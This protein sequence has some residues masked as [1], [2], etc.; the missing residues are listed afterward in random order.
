MQLSTVWPWALAAVLLVATLIVVLLVFL[1][2]KAAKA[3]K[4]PMPGEQPEMDEPLETPA[5]TAE[6]GLVVGLSEAFRKAGHLLDRV[7][8]GDRHDVPLLLLLGGAR[9]RDSDM[10]ARCGLDMPWGPPSEGGMSLGAGRGFWFYDRGAIV[11]LAGDAVLREDGKTADDKTWNDG[12]RHLVEL[13]PKRPVDGLIL[14]LSA[15]ELL[16]AASSEGRRADLASRAGRLFRRL[17]DAQQRLGFRLPTYVVVTGCERLTGFRSLCSG[18]PE[19]SRKQMLGWSSPYSIESVYRTAWIDEAFD[20]VIKRLEDVQMEIF[21]DGTAEAEWLLGLPK[22]VAALAGPVRTCLDNVFRPT[23]YHGALILRGVYFCGREELGPAEEAQPIG[24]V[25]FLHDLLDKKAFSEA[26]LAQPTARTAV[27]RSRNVRIAQWSTV[28]T[29]AFVTAALLWS[30]FL[31]DHQNKHVKPF[32][33]TAVDYSRLERQR[34]ADGEPLNRAELHAG[35]LELLTR[36]SEIDFSHYGPLTLPASWFSKFDSRLEQSVSVAFDDVILDALRF[37]LETRARNTITNA[38]AQLI[39]AE[40]ATGASPLVTLQNMPAQGLLTGIVPASLT[41]TMPGAL[42]AT[43]SMPA[44]TLPAQASTPLL[45]IDDMPELASLRTYVTEMRQLEATARSFNALADTGDINDLA[46]VIRYALHRNMPKKFFTNST[47]YQA[48]L[49][50]SNYERFRPQRYHDDASRALDQ[51]AGNFYAGLYRR[52]PFAL[53][54]QQLAPQLQRASWYGSADANETATFQ[55]LSRQLREVETALAGPE[56]EWA[57]RTTFDLGPAYD[58]IVPEIGQSAFFG[59]DVARDFRDDGMN[60]WSEFRTNIANASSLLTGPILAVENGN[61]QMR[62]SSDTLLLKYALDTFLGQAFVSTVPRGRQM[63]VDLPNGVRLEWVPALLDQANAVS[64]AYDRFREKSLPMFP[65]DMR[66][67]IDQVARDRARNEMFDLVADAQ[68]FEPVPPPVS[69]TQLE[70]EVAGGVATFNN[71]VASLGSISESFSRIGAT[72]SQRDLANA[73][74]SEAFRLLQDL[75]QLLDSEQPYVPRQGNFD[76]WDGTVPPSPAAWGAHD[77]AELATYLDAVRGRVAFLSSNYAKPLLAWFQRA[78]TA[79][80]PEIRLTAAKWQTIVDALAAYDA[81]KPGNA[82]AQ[83]EDYISTRAAKVTPGDCAS[84]AMPA[85]IRAS[86]GYYP[87]TL[88]NISRLLTDR[89]NAIAG[90]DAMQRYAEVARY[91]N[92]RLSGRYPFA[93]Q[94][95]IGNQPEADPA[96]IRAFFRIFDANKSVIS[97]APGSGGLDAAAAQARSFMDDMAHVRAFFAPYLDAPKADAAPAVDVEPTFRVMRKREIDGDQIIVWDLSIG[98]D[99]ITNRDKAAKLRWTA[100]DPVRVS[101]RWAIDAPRVPVLTSP[102]RWATVRDRT[103]TYEYT[104]RWA[105]ITALNAHSAS[106][107]ELPGYADIDPVTLRFRV[108][109]QPAEGGAPGDVASLV[110]MRLSL[111]A[112]GTTNVLDMPHFPIRAPRLDGKAAEEAP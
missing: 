99:S 26:G 63:R 106:A 4:Y 78:G 28:A 57:F 13:R 37:E 21:T 79:D 109:T 1:L 91:F 87:G 44:T 112:P 31:L 62:L 60:G 2:K 35:A 16:D 95:P 54:L 68:R 10:L 111:L 48:A 96:D 49:R 45:S 38:T 74:T 82:V 12:L 5:Q 20:V 92:A 71:T 41:Q 90:Q 30:W 108:H 66:V 67:S 88:Q 6:E 7:A 110:F 64:A 85:T 56:L 39:T 52:N 83:L 58:Q 50:A 97:A 81:K 42:S 105:L 24:N 70:D 27:A 65:A 19:A 89:C 18:I 47:L 102:Q 25:A 11:D 14:T 75:D 104:N 61:P 51:L 55:S 93:E 59:T 98:T 32:L 84:A 15:A 94:P 3:A 73:V 46:S 17:A 22:A 9:S 40:R 53:R 86:R 107:E 77:P 33:Q 8:D 103:I 69:P 36:M 101:L 72:D 29:A 34:I 43:P 100:G 23:A 76:W 80:R